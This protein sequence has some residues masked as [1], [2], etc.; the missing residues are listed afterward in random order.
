MQRSEARD[1]FPVGVLA[2]TQTERRRRLALAT[3]FGSQAT[4]NRS[5]RRAGARGGARVGLT[6]TGVGDTISSI[7]RGTINQLQTPDELRE[8]PLSTAFLP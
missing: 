5:T 2:Q 1:L 3:G 7:L 4:W 6:L 8:C